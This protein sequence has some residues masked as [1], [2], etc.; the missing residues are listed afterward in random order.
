MNSLVTEVGYISLNKK[1]EQLCGD[2]V[3]MIE[4][5]DSL[6]LVL[7]DG[8]GSGV[9]ANILSTLTSKIIP[10]M[11]ANGMPVSECVHTI[12]STLPVCSQRHVAYSTFTIIQINNNQEAY[13]VQYDNP[14]AILL[15]DGV[16]VDYPATEQVIDGKKILFSTIRLE[17]EDIFIAMSDG[18]LY[19]GVGMSLNF[20]WGWEN[21]VEYMEAQYEPGLTAKTACA[22]LSEECNHLYGSQPGD[23]TTVAAV[24]IRQRQQVNLMIGPPKDPADC[25]RMVGL[26]LSKEGK[27]VVCGGTTSGIVAD[28]LGKKV[29]TSLDYSDPEIPPIGH[30]DGID[31]VTEGV[32]T[33]SRVVEYARAYADA[34]DV[35]ADSWKYK[36]DGASLVA[37]MLFE[38]ATDINFFVGKAINPAHQN[39]NLPGFVA[40][41]IQL[42]DE[43]AKCL[44]KMGKRVKVSYF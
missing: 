12:A 21:I 17:P 10:T 30:I 3:E 41:K 38:T 37:Q 36:K 24:R 9:K 18:A 44:E 32:V 26:F 42:V 13:L 11:M 43:L 5:D 35:T 19:A 39:P 29:T 31:L 28:R 15:R 23:D 2:R 7:A 14:K 25:D 34:D 40:I 22:L 6:T 20:G 27:R 8:L 33:L 4:H 1:G 16:S